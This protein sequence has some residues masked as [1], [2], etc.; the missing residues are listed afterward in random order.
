MEVG[1]RGRRGTAVVALA[2]TAAF[3]AL[4]GPAAAKLPLLR[5][6][7]ARAE[8]GTTVSAAMPVWP[9]LRLER[10]RFF[11]VH[12]R[13]LAALFPRDDYAIFGK[14]ARVVARDER[15]LELDPVPVADS[16][17]DE[18]WITVELTIPDGIRT[19]TYTT[20]ALLCR[21]SPCVLQPALTP[22][23]MAI[24][25]SIGRWNQRLALRVG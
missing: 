13:D 23:R 2:A 21:P 7:Q 6:E 11:L 22:S 12:A 8:A 25:R 17:T 1:V 10:L 19:G 14:Q 16:E 18:G 9:Q 3:G 4:A 20:A 15:L 24:L 5:F